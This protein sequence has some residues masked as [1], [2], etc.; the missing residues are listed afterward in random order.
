MHMPKISGREVDLYRLYNEVIERG[1][2]QKVN[3]RDEWQDILPEIGYREKCV[4][5][6]AALK[7]IYRRVLEKYERLAFFGEDPDKV[8]PFLDTNDYHDLLSGGGRGGNRSRHPNN[9]HSTLTHHTSSIHNVP[10]NYNYRQ[11]SVNLDRRRQFKLSTNLYKPS[12]YEKLVLSLLS[13]LPNEQDFAINTCTLMANEAQHTLRINEYPKLLDALLAHTGVFSDHSMRE[14]FEHVYCGVRNHSLYAFWRDLLYK[15][16]QILNLYNNYDDI[17]TIKGTEKGEE[18]GMNEDQKA[19]HYLDMDFFNLGRDLGTHDYVG[20]RILQIISILRNLSFFEENLAVLVKNRSFLRFLVMSSNIRWNNIHVQALEITGNIANE[21]ELLDP[22]VDD[23]SRILMATICE[24]IEGTDRCTILSCLEILHKLCQKDSNEDYILKS[25]NLDI[26]RALV[27][28]MSLKDIMLLIYTLEAIYALTSLGPRSCQNLMQIRGIFDQL[29]S[30]MTVEGHS[31]GSDGCILMKVVETIPG[32]MLPIVMNLT[33][34]QSAAIVPG[35]TQ[36]PT[37]LHSSVVSIKQQHQQPQQLQQPQ[38]SQQQQQKPQLPPP[39]P[40]QLPNNNVIAPSNNHI[41]SQSS[42]TDS[43]ET[44]PVVGET[45]ASTG[46]DTQGLTTVSSL[47]NVISSAGATVED[48]Q[49]AL[50][51]LTANIERTASNENHIEKQE[52]YRHYVQYCQKMGK[53]TVVNHSQFPRLVRLIFT[54]NVG[55]VLIRRSDGTELPGFHYITIRFRA[56]TVTPTP[57]Q[58]KVLANSNALNTNLMA[59]SSGGATKANVTETPRKAKKKNKV[60]ASTG[61]DGEIAA[62]GSNGT[63]KEGTY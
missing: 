38:P 27:Q 21:L 54:N 31:Y 8:H 29:I 57:I 42:S 11:H 52:L 20:Q 58:P 33:N 10:M 63:R 4:N 49:Y 46:T 25:L 62:T 14:L 41:S 37:S 61:T 39:P 40:Q 19:D 34:L 6:T 23:L 3:N 51:W 48:E 28:L 7:Y 18:E 59:S 35:S 55:P 36:F 47:V 12:C 26:Y 30:L 24:A 2:F 50:S 44:A 1:G 32:S 43:S 9:H 5:G 60:D 22:T 17:G 13:P 45:S 16:P 15:R 53:G 56:P